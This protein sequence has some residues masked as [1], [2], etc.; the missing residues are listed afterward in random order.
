MRVNCLPDPERLCYAK[1]KSSL[2]RQAFRACIHNGEN[3]ISTVDR[4]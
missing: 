3:M 2:Q 1:E 4:K